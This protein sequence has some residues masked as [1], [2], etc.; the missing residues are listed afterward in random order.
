MPTG[1]TTCRLL[2]VLQGLLDRTQ[3]FQP[4]TPGIRPNLLD[5]TTWHDQIVFVRD[6]G[7]SD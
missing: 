2:L 7:E 5:D 3:L 6:T 4:Y 1:A